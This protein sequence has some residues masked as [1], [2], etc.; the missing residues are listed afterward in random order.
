MEILLLWI[1]FTFIVGFIGGNRKIGFLAAFLISLF[2]SPL[3]GLIVALTSS[4]KDWAQE[5][6]DSFQKQAQKKA[7]QQDYQ[8]AIDIM[9]QAMEK[10]NT[11]PNL[12]YRMATYYS[13]AN[14]TDL[15]LQHLGRA[16]EYGYSDFEKIVTD[17]NLENLRNTEKFAEFADRGYKFS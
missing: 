2:L 16:V 5:E 7:D 12:H 13:L 10:K 8:G 15:A 14:K 11:D 3:I 17:E 1:V 4:K 9:K 6:S